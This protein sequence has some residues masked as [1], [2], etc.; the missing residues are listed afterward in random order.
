MEFFLYIHYGTHY[1]H[2]IDL[3]FKQSEESKMSWDNS[4][5]TGD[6]PFPR[7]DNQATKAYDKARD[8]ESGLYQLGISFSHTPAPD[9]E[10]YTT[11]IPASPTGLDNFDVLVSPRGHITLYGRAH[12]A[13]FVFVHSTRHVFTS[14]FNKHGTNKA[15]K[16]I[17]KGAIEMGRLPAGTKAPKV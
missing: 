4:F 17:T 3:E 13:G 11:D 1:S 5:A 9:G 7:R 10:F 2:A 15:L 6:V 8:L 12:A 16:L 14:I